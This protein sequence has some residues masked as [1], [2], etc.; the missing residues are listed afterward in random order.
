MNKKIMQD[1]NP[2]K[3]QTPAEQQPEIIQEQQQKEVTEVAV[4]AEDLKKVNK[5][6]QSQ[7]AKTINSNVEKLKQMETITSNHDS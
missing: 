7:A 5:E 1:P 3:N 6:I 4:Q 2:Q